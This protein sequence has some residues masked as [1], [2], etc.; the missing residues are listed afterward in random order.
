MVNNKIVHDEL[1]F[2]TFNKIQKG[3]ISLFKK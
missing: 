2:C 1:Y 3:Q